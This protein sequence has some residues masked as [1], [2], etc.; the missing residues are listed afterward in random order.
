GIFMRWAATFCA[1]SRHRNSRMPDT[2]FLIALSATGQACEQLA[3]ST[4]AGEDRSST[5]GKDP[6]RTK[7]RA[8]PEI[9]GGAL[10][11]RNPTRCLRSAP[12]VG[13]RLRRLFG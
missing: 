1:V 3:D 2:A 9:S 4:A 5:G 8:P 11:F 6:V 12:V 13:G 10:S 7:T